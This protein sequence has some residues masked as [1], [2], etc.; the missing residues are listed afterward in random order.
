MPRGMTGSHSWSDVD[1]ITH[2]QLPADKKSCSNLTSKL[3]EHTGRRT[4]G[5]SAQ[6]S[7]A[8]RASLLGLSCTRIVSE[9]ELWNKE[10]E[11]EH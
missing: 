8:V 2:S 10:S 11:S 6:P 1:P 7:T 5:D 3:L 4:Q 9:W